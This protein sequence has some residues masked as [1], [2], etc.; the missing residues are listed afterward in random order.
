[1][2]R[3]ER[4]VL[5]ILALT[6]LYLVMLLCA[7]PAMA[8]QQ[9]EA[10]PVITIEYSPTPS[11]TPVPPPSTSPVAPATPTPELPDYDYPA[12]D[13]RCLSRAIWSVCPRN[14]THDTR[15]A[16]CELVQNRV[17][18]DSGDF[19]DTPR[20]VLLQGNE[21]PSYDPD[22]YR[23]REN[24]E[25]AD[26]AMRTWIYATVTGDRSY[27]LVPSEGLYCDFYRRSGWDYIKI[28]N[29]AGDVVYDSGANQK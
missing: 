16:L 11:P 10:A 23:S 4:L 3:L 13:A 26:Y 2:I 8:E 7:I 1:M 17:D 5:T 6:C 14:P 12:E 27:R 28:Y 29:R 24:N 19:E 15:V 25:I 18:D 20:W 9:P 22:A 21:F